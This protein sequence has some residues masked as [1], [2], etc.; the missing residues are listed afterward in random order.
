M[1]YAF[2]ALSL[3]NA[4]LDQTDITKTELSNYFQT[5]SL[6]KFYTTEKEK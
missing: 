6:S 3:K 2:A 4:V 5:F 1:Q